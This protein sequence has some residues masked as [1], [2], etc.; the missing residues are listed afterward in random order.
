MRP[1]R[2]REESSNSNAAVAVGGA[3]SDAPAGGLKA[4]RSTRVAAAA[5]RGR[6]PIVSYI[7]S[8]VCLSVRAGMLRCGT[9]PPDTE[10][11]RRLTGEGGRRLPKSP[12]ALL[13]V[14]MNSGNQQA[15]KVP[16]LAVRRVPRGNDANRSVVRSVVLCVVQLVVFQ[17]FRELR[18]RDGRKHLVRLRK[19]NGDGF[20]RQKG[21][22]QPRVLISMPGVPC[23]QALREECNELRRHVPQLTDHQVHLFRR[24][25]HLHPP[26]PQRLFHNH[27]L[28]DSG[29]VLRPA[30]RHRVA[31]RQKTLQRRGVR[32]GPV[33]QGDDGVGHAGTIDVD[34]HAQIVCHLPDLLQLCEGVQFAVLRRL[35]QRHHLGEGV[36]L[37]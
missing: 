27:R 37:G 31:Q 30:P 8:A 10:K 21:V 23:P 25:R 34:E 17:K 28:C 32:V 35:R 9:L 15:G 4:R 29:P 13:R 20:R 24:S 22:Q 33:R 11:R 19:R 14:A 6:R 26:T 1:R 2:K 3:A 36:E 18:A 12:S 16:A 5:P 7:Q